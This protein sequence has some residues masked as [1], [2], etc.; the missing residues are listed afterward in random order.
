ME[1]KIT[2]EEDRKELCLENETGIIAVPFDEALYLARRM[3]VAASPLVETLQVKAS[4]DILNHD[5]DALFNGIIDVDKVAYLT[6]Y[7]EGTGITEASPA[8]TTERYTSRNIWE[9]S[10]YIRR[11]FGKTV[12]CY[13][14]RSPIGAV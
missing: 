6:S 5:L 2:V 4:I 7:K 14:S 11:R 12:Q 13:V 3:I 1:T 8:S 9:V 10:E